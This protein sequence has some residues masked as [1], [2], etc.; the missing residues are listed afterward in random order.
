M[1]YK[2]ISG[3]DTPSQKTRVDYLYDNFC[4]DETLTPQTFIHHVKAAYYKYDAEVYN[5]DHT[6]TLLPTFQTIFSQLTFN[7]EPVIVDIGAGSGQTYDLVKRTE[8]K[9][10]KYYFIE[11]FQSMIDQFDDKDDEKI[12]VICDYYE[13]S[14]CTK[15]LKDE[16]G[17]KLFIM[18]ASMRTLDNINEFIDILKL[19]MKIGDILVLPLEPNNPYFGSYFKI[20]L[21]FIF[22]VRVLKK[23]RATFNPKRSSLPAGAKDSHPLFKS[24]EHLKTTGVVGSKFNTTMLYAVIYYNNYHAWRGIEIPDEYNDGFFTIAQVAERLGGE[25]SHLKTKEYLY[26]FSFGLA[27]LDDFLERTLAKLFPTKG[28]TLTAVITKI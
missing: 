22:C 19:N 9:F 2:A 3:D 17:S 1:K 24:L 10:S 27:K 23:V 15:L 13:G 20:L 5:P 14:Y 26:G 18:C 25:V 21:P 16:K 8:F 4:I 11:P 28:A 6:H 7:V 12:V